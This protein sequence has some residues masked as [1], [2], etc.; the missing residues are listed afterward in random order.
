MFAVCVRYAETDGLL[1]LPAGRYLC[2][3]STE[4]ARAETEKQLL[5]AAEREYGAAPAF[6]VAQI[7]VTGILQ[8]QYQIQ[9]Y[10]GRA[11]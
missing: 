6:T 5:L 8:W 7:I 3:E 1:T 2:A 11:A 4:E 9:V 10:I